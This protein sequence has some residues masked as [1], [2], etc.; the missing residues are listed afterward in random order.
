MHNHSPHPKPVF[1]GTGGLQGCGAGRAWIPPPAPPV[2]GAASL[3][4][5]I[6]F[7][8]TRGI[9]SGSALGSPGPRSPQDPRPPRP[10]DPLARAMAPG[11]QHEE[12]AR[13]GQQAGLQVWRVENLQL[14]P[15]PERAFGD[16]YVGDAYLV[17]HTAQK[18]RHFTYHLHFWLGKLYAEG[19]GSPVGAVW[20]GQAGS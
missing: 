8:I 20:G 14:V 11:L 7:R 3:R 16:F 19:C 4:P 18:S 5:A 12:F 13:A 6:K 15:V 10:A 2:P 17:L 1:R 9:E